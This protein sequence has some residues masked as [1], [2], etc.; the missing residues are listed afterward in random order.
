[1]SDLPVLL[2]TAPPVILSQSILSQRVKPRHAAIAAQ[3]ETKQLQKQAARR[4]LQQ[5]ERRRL[6]LTQQDFY[7]RLAR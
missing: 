7:Q 6:P 4:Q 5:A 3:S 2:A 1:M